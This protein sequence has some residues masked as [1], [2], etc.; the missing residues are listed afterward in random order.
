[1]LYLLGEQDPG[2]PFTVMRDEIA[3]LKAE[4]D[5]ITLISYSDGVHLLDGI[6]FWPEMAKWLSSEM[7]LN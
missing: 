1:M 6:G 4:G 3:I 2:I 5:D 7:I